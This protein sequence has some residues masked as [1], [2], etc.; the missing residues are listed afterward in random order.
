LDILFPLVEEIFTL[1]RTIKNST[2]N[3]EK[4]IVPKFLPKKPTVGEFVRTK[5][6]QIEATCHGDNY[7]NCGEVNNRFRLIFK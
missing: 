4:R 2:T 5:H 7:S 3:K 6:K 1:D